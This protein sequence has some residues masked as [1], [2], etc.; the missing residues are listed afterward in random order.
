MAET[1]QVKDLYFIYV[2]L[3]GGFNF[4]KFSSLPGEMIQF[5]YIIFFKCVETTMYIY[6]YIHIR[7]A[8]MISH[9]LFPNRTSPPRTT[10]TVVAFGF[11]IGGDQ[12]HVDVTSCREPGVVMYFPRK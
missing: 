8:Q 7:I 2:Y 4:L 9:F 11:G 12:S 1:I 5:D 3:G 6:I 10:S